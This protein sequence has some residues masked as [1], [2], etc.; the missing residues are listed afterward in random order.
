M[1]RPDGSF[2]L[3]DFGASSLTVGGVTYHIFRK[4]IQD[5]ELRLRSSRYRDERPAITAEPTKAFDILQFLL[6]FA[7]KY[8]MDEEGNRREDGFTEDDFANFKRYFAPDKKADVDF[9]FLIQFIWNY[10]RNEPPEGVVGGHTPVDALFHIAYPN[11]IDLF[12]PEAYKT[13][14]SL[15]PGLT[16]K[17]FAEL[18]EAFG[19][20]VGRRTGSKKPRRRTFRLRRMRRRNT[21]KL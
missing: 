6:A 16:A 9:D 20:P 10:F 8:L 1:Y 15:I 11:F 13:S 4:N 5:H 2:V 19:R 7:S 17:G 12:W 3:I 21:R 18:S 14:L